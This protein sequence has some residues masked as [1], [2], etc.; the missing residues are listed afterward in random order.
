MHE[1]CLGHSYEIQLLITIYDCKKLK[2]SKANSCHITGLYKSIRQGI[3]QATLLQACSL[4]N[5]GCSVNM[6]QCMASTLV[7]HKV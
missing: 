2:Q 6:N 3:T 1:F 7:E 5:Q 4:W